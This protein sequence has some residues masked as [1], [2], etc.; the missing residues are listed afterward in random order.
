LLSTLVE[1]VI[2]PAHMGAAVC[3]ELAAVPARLSPAM[4]E[5]HLTAHQ[6]ETPGPALESPSQTG[7]EM[8]LPHRARGRCD[9]ANTREPKNVVQQTSCSCTNRYGATKA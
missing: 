4:K 9:E 2:H 8:P 3:T 5:A 1:T 6:G 7:K